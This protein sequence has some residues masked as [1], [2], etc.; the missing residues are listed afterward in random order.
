M[1]YKILSATGVWSLD[2]ALQ[3]LSQAVNN[4]ISLGWEPVGGVSIT[5]Y[6]T[7]V[8]AMIKRR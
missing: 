6:N 7:A 3:N 4:A 8:Q 5:A 2:R 1:E